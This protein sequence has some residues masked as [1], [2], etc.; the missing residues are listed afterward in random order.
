MATTFESRPTDLGVDADD[1][2]ALVAV[3]GEDVLV[4][5]DAVGVV[6]AQHVAVARQGVWSRGQRKWRPVSFRA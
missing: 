2:V 4:A 5:L 6:L 3:V 1:L